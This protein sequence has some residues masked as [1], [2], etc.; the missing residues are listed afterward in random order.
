MPVVTSPPLEV[1]TLHAKLD[2]LAGDTTCRVVVLTG[3]GRGFCSGLD[4]T[5]RGM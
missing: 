2:R 1:E 5:K 4:L 3:A